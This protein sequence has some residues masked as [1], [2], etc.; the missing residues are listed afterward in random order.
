MSGRDVPGA[1]VGLLLVV[2]VRNPKFTE[3]ERIQY[4]KLVAV[5]PAWIPVDPRFMV[6]GM[7][8]NR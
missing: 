7:L 5:I 3:W 4:R 6:L 1:L 2:M 8:S